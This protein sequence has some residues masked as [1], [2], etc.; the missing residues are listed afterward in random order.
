[1]SRIWK[2]EEQEEDEEGR[3]EIMLFTLIVMRKDV[4][5]YKKSLMWDGR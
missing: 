1:M 5:R 4:Y 2:D 3:M